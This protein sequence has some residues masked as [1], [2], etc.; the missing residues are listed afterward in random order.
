M[1]SIL[2][3]DINSYFATLLQQEN[4]K[5]RG[6]PLGII[7]DVGRT[8]IIAASKEAKLCGV[9]TGCSLTEAKQLCPN[10]ITVPADFDRYLD[11]TYRLK[12]IF[13]TISPQVYIYSLDEAFID[14]TDCQKY[15][16]PSP[17]TLATK[18][19]QKIKIELGNW[20]TC[21]VGI[22][23]NRLLAKIASE[24]SPKGSILEINKTN[25]DAILSQVNFKDVCGIGYR[26]SKKLTRLGVT[27]PY[28]IRFFSEQD[29]QPLFGPFWS[30]ELLRIAYGQESYNLSLIS[31]PNT[32]MKSVGRSITGYK[33][34][35][36][37]DEIAKI[38][39]NLTE[40]VT[41]KVRKMNLA[42][43]QVSIMLWGPF[44]NKRPL[45][46]LAP[47]GSPIWNSHKTL[48]FY[49]SHTSEMFQIIYHE[50]Y[51]NWQ[52]DFKI[53]KFGVRLSLLEPIAQVPQLL[54]PKQQKLTKLYHAM[55]QVSDKYGLFTL[56]SARMMNQPVIRPEVTGFLGDRIYLEL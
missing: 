5:L 19:Q 7:K 43:R 23:P 44:K 48:K 42:G 9:Q 15:L 36:D 4:P 37:E 26:L 27:H 14:I 45:G 52:R 20:V 6:R 10:F 17:Y 31:K 55:D 25:R 30:K 21:N 28:Q 32:Q 29:L 2:H 22:G 41:Y 56:K 33:L 12:K 34:Y 16:Y 46:W 50:L 13:S 18:I 8:C 47:T 54:W 3:V 38:I 1:H 51:R 39:Y 49:V 24:I 53:I 11:A 35:D 40:E